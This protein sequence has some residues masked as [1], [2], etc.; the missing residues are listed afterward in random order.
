MISLFVSELEAMGGQL[1]MISR[2]AW[3]GEDHKLVSATA[4]ARGLTPREPSL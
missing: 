4:K 3:G 2:V 1:P